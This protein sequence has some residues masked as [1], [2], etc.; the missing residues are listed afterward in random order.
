MTRLEEAQLSRRALLKYVGAIGLATACGAAAPPA[1]SPTVAA[2][3]SAAPTVATKWGMSAAD[4]AAWKT[5]ED[6]AVKEGKVTYYS[7]GTV[8]PASVDK[9][10]AEFAKDYPNIAVEYLNVGNSTQLAARITTEQQAKTYVADVADHSVRSALLLTVPPTDFYQ[11]FLPPAA[12]DPTVKWLA[13]PIADPDKKGKID[14]ALAQ[15]FAIWTNTK[16]VAAADLPKNTLDVATNP[17]WK[18]QII[19]RTPW[20]SGG[21][22]HLYVFAEK[23][24]GRDWVTKMQAQNVTFADDQDAA[25][26]QVARGE[27]AIGLGLTGR[28]GADLI[29]QGLPVKAVWP[30][31][32][33]IT[34]TQ[35][36]QFVNGAPHPN[37]AKVFINWGLT[38]RGQNFWRDLGQFPLN[39]AIAPAEE[40][41]KGVNN[42]KT[43]Y[44][45]LLDAK[46]QQ[47]SYDAATK[48]FKK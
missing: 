23:V 25:L 31:D 10:K 29:K 44:E 42:A 28:Q 47:A 7:L 6:A 9:L 33:V 39:S 32:F 43:V 18:G 30:N 34:S 13:D 27:Y 37:A 41:M 19:M 45:N 5:I 1:A 38:E 15:F 35:G 40:W 46:A 4:A 36:T 12:K 48:D 3:A 22:N 11:A 2:T 14:A 20:T 21:G 8:P 24:Y 26:L 17:K 16:M